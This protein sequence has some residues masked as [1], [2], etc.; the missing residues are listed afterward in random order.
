MTITDWL[1]VSVGILTGCLFTAAHYINGAKMVSRLYVG[2]GRDSRG[3][4]W[5]AVAEGT[6]FRSKSEAVKDLN[7]NGVYEYSEE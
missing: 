6:R 7:S 4:Y 2:V 1:L 3:W 5:R